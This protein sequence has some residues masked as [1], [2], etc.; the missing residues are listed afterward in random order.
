[1]AA[2]LPGSQSEVMFRN[3]CQL[4]WISTWDFFSENGPYPISRLENQKCCNWICI[5]VCVVIKGLKIICW[6][7]Q[8]YKYVLSVIYS[9][10]ML[11]ATI[12]VRL[13]WYAHQHVISSILFIPFAPSLH[14]FHSPTIHIYMMTSSNGNNFRVTGHLC[15]EFT[16]PRWIPHT[17]ASDAELWSLLWSAPE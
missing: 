2:V 1:M 4:K 15:G 14:I 9:P 10:Q 16:G 12:L 6:H 5:V 7:K 8:K 11:I 17:K 13:P 3:S